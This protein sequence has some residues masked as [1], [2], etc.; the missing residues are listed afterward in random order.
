ML[1]QRVSRK[2]GTIQSHD[3]VVLGMSDVIKVV[4]F[5][6][7]CL[8]DFGIKDC[9]CDRYVFQSVEGLIDTGV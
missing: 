1:V 3:M 7:K 5:E 6:N 2:I 4:H 9:G 8:N